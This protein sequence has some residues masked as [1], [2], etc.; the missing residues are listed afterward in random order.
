MGGLGIRWICGVGAGLCAVSSLQAREF[1]PRLD[2]PLLRAGYPRPISRKVVA[3]SQALSLL[4]QTDRNGLRN[5]R[6]HGI[7]QAFGP[8]ELTV[9]AARLR[10]GRGGADD[11]MAS[12]DHYGASSMV[13]NADFDLGNGLHAGPTA[14]LMHMKRHFAVVPSGLHP[15][16]TDITTAGFRISRNDGPALS[17]DYVG[18]GS[19]RVRPLDRMAEIA[20][21]APLRGSGLRLGL[22]GGDANPHSGGIAWGL[23]LSAMRRPRSEFAT[24]EAPGTVGD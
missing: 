3:K 13:M 7:E 5:V 8:I 16:S 1:D 22:S 19:R 21:G 12:G 24:N 2:S 4:G 9:E 18:T 23:T 11:V 14:S 10:G 6:A 20:D 15:R 17:L